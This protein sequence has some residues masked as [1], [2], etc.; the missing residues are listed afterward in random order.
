M[1]IIITNFKEKI[2]KEIPTII[3]IEEE[4]KIP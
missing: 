3:T 2:K 1:K 4:D